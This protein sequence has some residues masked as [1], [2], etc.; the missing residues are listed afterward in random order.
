MPKV[1][2]DGAL[3]KIAVRTRSAPRQLLQVPGSGK[4]ASGSANT[5]H[6]SLL[7]DLLTGQ[8]AGGGGEATS[9][10]PLDRRALLTITEHVYDVVL[11][12]EQMKRI[13][14]TLLNEIGMLKRVLE[15]KPDEEPAQERL[16]TLEANLKRWENDYAEKVDNLW[17]GLRVMDPLDAWWASL[18]LR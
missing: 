2:V 17:R 12:L 13:H 9:D 1:T 16:S 6:Q 3:G 14:Q 8:N 10:K 11:D 18:S 15:E 4:G 7:D 5:A